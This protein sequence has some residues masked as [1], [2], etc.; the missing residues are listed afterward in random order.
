MKCQNCGHENESNSIYCEECGG[1]LSGSPSFGR[2]KSS[3]RKEGMNTTNK[4]LI[5]SIIIL[6]IVLG[7]MV[8]FLLRS[9]TPTNNSTITNTTPVVEEEISLSNGFP[10][11]KVP[12][13]A[14]EIVKS[15]T[16]FNSI[17]YSG[18]TLDKNQCLYL[19]SRGIVMINNGETG[20]IPIKNYEDPDN[21][22]GTA[23]SATITK[24]DYVDMAQR[25]YTWMDSY[26]ISPNYIGIT[27]SG[28]PDLSMDNMLSLYSKILAQYK[29]SGQL[30]ETVTFP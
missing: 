13:L 17:T 9:P 28:E 15:G 27:V 23:S 1:R 30:P 7:V 8:G 16:D 4:I 18:V 10:V 20:N 2:S 21:P 24:N 12:D 3:K 11:S 25:T 19:L 26:G 6:V 29:S 5:A 14:Q 22:Y